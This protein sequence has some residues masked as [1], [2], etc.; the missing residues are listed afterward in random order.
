MCEVQGSASEQ[1]GLMGAQTRPG[2][3]KGTNIQVDQFAQRESWDVPSKGTDR[4]QVRSV[5]YTI[6]P[7]K[8]LKETRK[9]DDDDNDD[10]DEFSVW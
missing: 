9:D 10:D 7:Y 2:F 5:Y 8:V 6:V 4:S 1:G 3:A